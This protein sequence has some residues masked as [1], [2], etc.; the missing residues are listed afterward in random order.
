MTQD[1]RSTD[2][3]FGY[4]KVHE[5]HNYRRSKGGLGRRY[6]SKGFKSLSFINSYNEV[7]NL[8]QV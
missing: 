5:V 4:G 3:I 6:V 8:M 1:K 7:F 2:Y